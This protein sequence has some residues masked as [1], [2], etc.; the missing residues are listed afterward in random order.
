LATKYP[1]ILHDKEITTN[2][3]RDK[4]SSLADDLRT[5]NS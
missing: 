4:D 1:S 3:W 2:I 5:V